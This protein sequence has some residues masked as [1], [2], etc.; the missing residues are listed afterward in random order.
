MSFHDKCQVSLVEQ[1]EGGIGTRKTCLMGSVLR[2]E[3]KGRW[4]QEI[5]DDMEQPGW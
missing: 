5:R 1:G 3:D 2:T 4:H